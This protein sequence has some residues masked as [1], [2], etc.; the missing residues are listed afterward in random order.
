[1]EGPVSYRIRVPAPLRLQIIN[2][3]YLDEER[4]VVLTSTTGGRDISD[5][6]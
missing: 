1:M 3:A 2:I 5:S 4:E 6:E